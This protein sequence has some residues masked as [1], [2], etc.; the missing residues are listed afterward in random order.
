MFYICLYT[1]NLYIGVKNS[2]KEEIKNYAKEIGVDD[3]G[4]ASVENYI[5]PNTLLLK[6]FTLKRRLLL[7]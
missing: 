1:N 2:M 5:S 6:R 7:F 4:F 3:I